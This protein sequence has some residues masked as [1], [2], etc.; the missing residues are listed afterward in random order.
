MLLR[1]IIFRPLLTKVW[2][3]LA[4]E[5]NLESQINVEENNTSILWN[6]SEKDL[7][8]Y[9]EIIKAVEIITKNN[10]FSL[11]Y[12]KTVETIKD[13]EETA[14]PAFHLAGTTRMS[15]N[16]TGAVV[17]EN[18]KLLKVENCYVLGSSV[19]TT[20]GWVNPTLTIMALSIRTVEKSWLQ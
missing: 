10:G 6:L 19:F 3:Q 13:L 20:A 12:S 8:N 4:Q 1:R 15:K 18:C 9:F 14:L 17:D 7:E 11:Y 5:S 2:I 16:E